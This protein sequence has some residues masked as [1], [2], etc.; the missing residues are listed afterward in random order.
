[1]TQNM[2]KVDVFPSSDGTFLGGIATKTPLKVVVV[3]AYK[4]ND[5][6]RQCISE[7]FKNTLNPYDK[8][9]EANQVY[10]HNPIV[11]PTVRDEDFFPDAPLIGW[12]YETNNN[13]VDTF[14]LNFNSSN[15]QEFLVVVWY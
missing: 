7:H 5:I 9:Y 15:Y 8:K 14:G 3:K 10:R 1:M 11:S 12:K 13:V 2:P 6:E 4:G